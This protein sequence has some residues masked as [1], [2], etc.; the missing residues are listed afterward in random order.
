MTAHAA[1]L[2]L[3][4]AL[5][6]ALGDRKGI[7][8]FGDFTAPLDE[9]LVHVVLV[10]ACS[11]LLFP[12]VPVMCLQRV[13]TNLRRILQVPAP[14]ALRSPCAWPA[15][16]MSVPFFPTLTHARLPILAKGNTAK[17]APPCV[18]MQSCR[19]CCS[20]QRSAPACRT[21]RGGPT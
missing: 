16:C 13:F 6:Q 8:R 5:A 12:S 9:A 4:G 20:P 21:C 18:G 10:R 15:V 1:A 3:G 2:A 19:Q 7:H 11:R 17:A 14:P